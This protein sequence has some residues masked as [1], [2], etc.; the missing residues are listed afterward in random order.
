M[1]HTNRK[2]EKLFPNHNMEEQ[3]ITPTLSTKFKPTEMSHVRR[4][5]RELIKDIKEIS[6]VDA[7][8]RSARRLKC[9][10]IQQ[11]NAYNEERFLELD[12]N[13]CVFSILLISMGYIGIKYLENK[14]GRKIDQ[15]LYNRSRPKRVKRFSEELNMASNYEHN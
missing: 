14:L 3:K 12:T 5:L 10:T 8:E 7:P 6:Q 2:Y 15:A 13:L 9:D 4:E 1:N 11:L